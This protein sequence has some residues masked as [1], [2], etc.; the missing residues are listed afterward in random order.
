MPTAWRF[1]KTDIGAIQPFSVKEFN[2]A[3]TKV[4]VNLTG[5]TVILVFKA[6]DGTVATVSG[7]DINITDAVNGEGEFTV[8]TALTVAE[9]TWT[10][11]QVK[12]TSAGYIEH[13]DPKILKIE[14]IAE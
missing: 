10:S 4:A 5:K 14:P 8:T 1:F 3:G 12:L 11:G 13:T 9:K 7:A 6:R 2:A